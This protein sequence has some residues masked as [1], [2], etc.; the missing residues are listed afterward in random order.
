MS[1]QGTPRPVVVSR[2]QGWVGRV[3]ADESEEEIARDY[4]LTATEVKEALVY[5]QAA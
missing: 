3:N 4:G 2:L 5:E 1:P